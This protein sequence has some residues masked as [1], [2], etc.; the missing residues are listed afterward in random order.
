[1]RKQ[2]KC[3]ECGG[4]LVKKTITHVPPWGDELYRFEEVP[5]LVCIQCGHVWLPAEV[6][7]LIDE[8]VQ[9]HPKPKKYQKVPVFSLAELTNV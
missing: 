7:Q 3:G 4:T 2:R 1:M 6:S 8:I 5:A 9:E